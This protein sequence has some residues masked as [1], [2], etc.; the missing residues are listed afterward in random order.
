MK[1]PDK[2]KEHLRFQFVR[3]ATLE[4]MVDFDGKDSLLVQFFLI[5]ASDRYQVID[6]AA[7][8]GFPATV[9]RDHVRYIVSL[10]SCETISSVISQPHMIHEDGSIEIRMNP[11]ILGYLRTRQ[12]VSESESCQRIRIIKEP[13]KPAILVDYLPGD[14]LIVDGGY[15]RPELPK[16]S[17]EPDKFQDEIDPGD[18]IGNRTFLSSRSLDVAVDER[19][20]RFGETF[21]PLPRRLHSQITEEIQKDNIRIPEETIP[22]FFT[23]DLVLLES[24]MDAVLSESA[25]RIRIR[26]EEFRP[27]VHVKLL[28]GG[29]L[30][31][32]I[33]FGDDQYRIPSSLL[34]G[35]S[36]EFKKVD[37]HT[38][39]A[40]QQDIVTLTENGLEA[41]GFEVT[42]TGYRTHVTQFATIEEFIERIGGIKE[43][44]E[45]YREF[46][47]T[48]T[49]FSLD[50][51]FMLP[52]EIEEQLVSAGFE[53]RRY[54]RQG[55]HW[56]DWLM[57]H[58]LHALLADDMGLGKTLQSILGLIL[59]LRQ[60]E[61]GFERPNLVICPK[62]V[63]R[64]WAREI[65]RCDPEV[66]VFEYIGE[67][68]TIEM[69]ASTGSSSPLP[70][71]TTTG[72]NPSPKPIDSLPPASLTQETSSREAHT[73]FHPTVVISSYATIT[74]DIELIRPIPLNYLILDEA[75][76]IKNPAAKRTKAIKSINSIH[77]IALTGT[78]IENRLSELWSV[79]DFLMRGYLGNFHHFQTAF[80]GP[81]SEGDEDAADKLARRIRPFMLRRLKDEV[82]EQLPEKIDVLEYC[83][84]SEEQK[85]LYA[86][87][88]DMQVIP[89]R[90]ALEKGERVNFT[91]N[92]LPI[93]TK[94]KQVCDHPSLVNDVEKPYMG[95]S[96]KFDQVIRKI[97]EILRGGDQIVIFS[98]FLQMLDLIGYV[99]KERGISFMRV[100]G[101][102]TNRQQYFDDFNEGKY[103]V[104]LLS[105][106]AC[107]HGINLTGANHVIHVDRWWNPAVEDQATDRVHRIGQ[108]KSVYVHRIITKGTLEER[109]HA[110][111]ERKRLLSDLVIGA[112]IQEKLEWT[113]D[114]LI[115]LLGPINA[116]ETSEE[117]THRHGSPTDPVLIEHPSTGHHDLQHL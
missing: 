110:L 37:D 83:E 76:K 85:V 34:F 27:Y 24:D 114:D 47:E 19:H 106:Q 102:T 79:F 3:D 88:Q 68:R 43:V 54:Q 62:S 31:F 6:P 11:S 107:G 8:Q 41:S 15:T 45:A 90:T 92:I 67:D 96:R 98:H 105:I 2:L 32:K 17:S 28:E 73:I 89:L 56:L 81:I 5:S 55:I 26:D 1:F 82:E 18:P 113:R 104:A 77:R 25:K 61:T 111:L 117:T 9:D 30:D 42:E 97:Q 103:E 36:N 57:D 93:L 20:V 21:V 46:L 12:G 72:L 35:A 86:E 53:L 10:A 101:S 33:E 95:R 87:I 38:W 51:G 75:T 59:N 48:L 22:E 108:E 60:R 64:H 16:D 39:M 49:D 91:I 115:E 71:N 66:S 65:E 58:H 78:P 23:R 109:I 116:P 40:V 63:I 29:W 94:L 44:N 80:E 52:E 14:G 74:R 7:L 70:S 69:F 4:F 84:L 112:A 99:L 13:M 100:D 50:A